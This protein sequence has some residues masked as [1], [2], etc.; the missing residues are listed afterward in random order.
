MPQ[1]VPQ[2]VSMASSSMVFMPASASSL[3]SV[4]GTQWQTQRSTGMWCVLLQVEELV[5]VG[6]AE[7]AEVVLG[8]VGSV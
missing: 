8:G 1:P 4:N 2:P 7:P 3:S 5:R 6:F